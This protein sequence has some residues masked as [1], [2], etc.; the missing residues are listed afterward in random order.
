MYCQSCHFCW[1]PSK[2]F[3]KS[4]VH[5]H[6]CEMNTKFRHDQKQ[7]S[8][9]VAFIKFIFYVS[10]NKIAH[11]LFKVLDIRWSWFWFDDE[12][13]LKTMSFT[14]ARVHIHTHTHTHTHYRPEIPNL[15]ACCLVWIISIVTKVTFHLPP[16]ATHL[17]G[18]WTLPSHTLVL[19]SSEAL[20]LFQW[21]EDE[22]RIIQWREDE[23]KI[24]HEEKMKM[25]LC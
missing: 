12:K 15:F 5:T 10:G 11:T 16:T 25:N 1:I 22:N 14:P 24:C 20:H 18:E 4:T 23:D 17:L 13:M 6:A 3:T 19:C 8:N 7:T 9:K 2:A 21:R